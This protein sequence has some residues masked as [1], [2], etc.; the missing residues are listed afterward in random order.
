[1]W[2][3]ECTCH[4]GTHT[5]SGC[6]RL[7][8]VNGALVKKEQPVAVTGAVRERRKDNKRETLEERQRLFGLRSLAPA[9]AK[10]GFGVQCF[11]LLR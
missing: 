2:P 8:V 5:E 3:G 7:V 9:G 6:G 11:F 10:K 4:G 1:M